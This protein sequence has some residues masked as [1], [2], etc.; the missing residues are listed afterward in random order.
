M[1]LI[2]HVV[3]GAIGENTTVL[4][5]HWRNGELGDIFLLYPEGRA[6]VPTIRSASDIA[7]ESHGEQGTYLL[8]V[9]SII[10]DTINAAKPTFTSGSLLRKAF[11]CRE[12]Q[13]A[14]VVQWVKHP[15]SAQV[16]IS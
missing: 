8:F 4:V 2:C 6:S 10:R 16:M 1:R 9:G 7:L 11:K 5:R 15:T 3:F 13:S 12:N 14:S